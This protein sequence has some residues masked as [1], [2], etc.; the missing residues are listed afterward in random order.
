MPTVNA[1]DG[2]VPG[3]I[4]AALCRTPDIGLY[5]WIIYLCTSDV[6][7][8]KFHAHNSSNTR[9]WVYEKAEWAAIE[10]ERCVTL[11]K[12]GRLPHGKTVDDVDAALRVIPIN[13]VPDIDR[14]RFHS[15]FT[16]LVWFREAL[17]RLHTA[18][19]ITV[20]N[21]DKL[22]EKLVYLATGTSYQRARKLLEEKP[23]IM[24]PTEYTRF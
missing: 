4:L 24:S 22:E 17:R 18:G 13:V 2:H 23:V 6:G 5:H 7:G 16:C 11:T 14:P 20:I 19:I 12:I 9:P 15:R 10:S 1:S 8:Y 21:L 3:N